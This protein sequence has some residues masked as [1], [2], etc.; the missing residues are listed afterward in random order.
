M[1]GRN[2]MRTHQADRIPWDYANPVRTFAAELLPLRQNGL[3][4]GSR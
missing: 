2:N 4:D 1:E 3:R